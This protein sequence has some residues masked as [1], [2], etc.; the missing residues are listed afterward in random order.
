MFNSCFVKA[1][2]RFGSNPSSPHPENTR[3]LSTS[4]YWQTKV[5]TEAKH[6]KQK[7]IS[8]SVF[9]DFFFSSSDLYKD[10]L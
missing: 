6:L 8:A 5:D 4:T 7:N 1:I 2:Q 9:P 3:N 10:L